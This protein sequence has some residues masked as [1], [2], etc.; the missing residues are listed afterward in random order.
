MAL[1]LTEPTQA[2]PQ[3][4]GELLVSQKKQIEAALPKHL[5]AD[6]MLRI[7]MTEIRKTP[8]LK[9]C[10][11]ASLIGSVIQASQLGLEPGSALGHAYLIPF[12][13]YKLS[14]EK[15][16]LENK[17]ISV[18]ECQFM[19]GYRGMIDLARR[20]GQVM[21]LDAQEVYENDLFEFEYGLNQKLR[22]IPT[23]KEPGHFIGVYAIAH[24]KEGGHQMRVIWKAEVD[25][26]RKSS[27]SAEEGPW[28]T[29]Y[30]EMAKKTVIR[31]L[32]KYLPVSVEMQRAIALDE[33]AE[34]GEQNNAFIIENEIDVLRLESPA[35][36]LT[37]AEALANQLSH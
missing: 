28:V 3:T 8:K 2:K 17:D 31:K 12:K 1:Q 14:K 9:L 21:S 25:K 20:S 34:R 15:S 19:L 10:T 29:H 22:H 30:E 6:R 26:V 13:N 36:S 32:F 18:M 27:K 24:L 35:V 7:V 37:K 5:N 11:P 23:M 33:S 16:K 4:I